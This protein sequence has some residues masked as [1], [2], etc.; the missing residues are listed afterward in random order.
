MRLRRQADVLR[1]RSQARQI[2]GFLGFDLQEQAAIAAAV[3][4]IARSAQ[5]QTNRATLHFQVANAALQVFANELPS[6]TQPQA[7]GSPRPPRRIDGPGAR[8]LWACLATVS[9]IGDV[10]QL[11]LERPLPHKEQPLSAEDLAWS[12]Q[13]VSRRSAPNLYAEV[14]Q[15]NQEILHLLNALRECQER[16]AGLSREPGGPCAA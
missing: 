3:F 12:V 2:A 8:R 16:L 11:R 10:A 13:E 7:G 14:R 4:E 9:A 5:R 6:R 15:Q 1:A